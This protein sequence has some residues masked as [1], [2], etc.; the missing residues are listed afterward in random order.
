MAVYTNDLRLKEIATGDESGTWG[1]STNTNLSL[2]A[3]AFSFGTEAITTNADTHTTTIADGAADP[4]RS[5]FLKYTGTLDSACTI[6]IGPNTVSKLWFIENATSGS[7]NII[8]KQGSGATVTIANGQTK[9]IYSDGAG[10][11]GAMVDAFQDL[12][13]PDLFIDDD[14]TFTSDSAVITFGA[15]GDTTLTHTDGSGLTLNSTNKL[16]FNDASQ[17]IQGSS[18]TVLSLGATDEIDLTATAIDVNGTMDVS[19]A[20]TGTTATL[21]TADNLTQLQLVSTDTDAN[22]GPILDLFRSVGS[23]AADSDQTGSILFTGR[24]DAPETITYARINSFISDASD[25]TEDGLL[26]LKHIVAGTEVAAL[27]LDATEYVFNDSSLDVDFRVESDSSTHALFVQASD[28]SVGF[29][30]SNPAMGI[31]LV[32]ANNSQL[33]IDS[34]DTNDTTL[35][36]DYNGG[37]ATNRIRLRNNAGDFAIN[38]DNTFEAFKVDS[39][40]TVFTT[41]TASGTAIKAESSQAGSGAGPGLVLY[42]N[43]SS[44]ADNDE[45]G[46]VTFEGRNDASQ[47]VAYALIGSRI[48]DASDGTEDGGLTISTIFGGTNRSRIDFSDTET[49]VN[50][51]GQNLDFRVES[52]SN[53]HMLFVD[54]GNNMVGINTSSPSSKLT[55]EGD[56]TGTTTGDISINTTTT[57]GAGRFIFKHSGTSV[58]QIAYSHDNLDLEIIAQESSSGI[59]FMTGGINERVHI[60]HGGT[61]VFNDGSNDSDFR[62]ESDADAN[63]FF[64]N[65]GDGVVSF[66]GMGTNTRNPSSVVPKFQANSLTRMDSSISLCCNSDDTLASLIMFSKTRS[67]NLTGATVCQA[68]DAVGAITWNAADGT[69][70][71]NGIAAIDAVV[72]SGIGSNDTPGALRF[73]TN[74]GTT[75]ASERLRITSAGHMVQGDSGDATFENVNKNVFSLGGASSFIVTNNSALIN[76]RQASDGNLIQFYGLT[77]GAT[78]TGNISQSGGTVSYGAFMANHPSEFTGTE[79]EVLVGTVMETTGAVSDIASIEGARLP[80]TAISS[81]ED[82]NA[83]YGV[84]L[85]TNL[86]GT[87]DGESEEAGIKVASI[88]AYFVRVHQSETPQLGDLLSS[89]GDGTAKVQSDDVIRSRT[90]GKVVGTVKK[91]TYDDGSYLLPCVLYCG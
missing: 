31:D 23:S 55:I 63:A 30:K 76:A 2:I 47:D 57:A 19:G 24:N 40:G 50:Q 27:R 4:G 68:G 56:A 33:R 13:I 41:T 51:S 10:S 85:G 3:D 26:H 44:P 60:D 49:N 22:A 91:Q 12:S 61:F 70:I 86:A 38:V 32:A 89:K 81:T 7:Q 65:G 90:I 6:T 53:S 48:I 75:S 78:N 77:N 16:M 71:N 39:D 43:S 28:G 52:D 83:V 11:G 42:R 37:G 59:K 15:D 9:A 58:G 36:L 79:T 29:N 25:G 46:S 5:I 82:S 72:E 87:A 20:L 88:G 64:V 34:S 8:I 35:F 62:I 69:D 67:A 45:T 74:S 84:Y 21:T 18:A 17:F 80:A 1:T 14:L 54:A 73:Y 66:G